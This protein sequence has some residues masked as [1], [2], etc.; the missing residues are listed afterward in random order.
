MQAKGAPAMLR[1][2]L[3]RSTRSAVFS[4]V[5]FA[6]IARADQQTVAWL[7]GVGSWNNAAMWSGGVVPNNS[8]TTTYNVLIDGGRAGASTVMATGAANNFAVD[9]LA[10]DA[11]DQFTAGTLSITHSLLL[12]G[13]LSLQS[14]S[15]LLGGS[16]E[17]AG[18]GTLE[19]MPGLA[20]VY[21]RFEAQ[22]G[23]L[24]IGEGITVRGGTGG[25][26]RWW[27]SISSLGSPTAALVN[28][29]R[30]V[31][32]GSAYR[33]ELRLRANAIENTGTIEAIN[34]S[35][36][37]IS[38]PFSM[39]SIGHLDY[40]GGSLAVYGALDNTG[41]ELLVDAVHGGL[42]INGTLRGGTLTTRDN[43]VV[44]VGEGYAANLDG[45]LLNA[46]TIKARGG[47]TVPAGQRFE[48]FADI[49]L[50]PP[51][52]LY[53]GAYL[54]AASGTTHITKGIRVHGGT[55]DMASYLGGGVGRDGQPLVNEGSIEADS[56][57]IMFVR[58]SGIDNLGTFGAMNGSHLS[59]RN[60]VTFGSGSHYV[61]E[62]TGSMSVAGDLDL[63]SIANFLD[64]KPRPDRKSYDGDV[65]LTY[66]GNRTGIFELT[67][68]EI[69]VGY[70]ADKTI[71]IW[72]RPPVP[73]SSLL[74]GIAGVALLRR[75]LRTGKRRH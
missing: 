56:G 26:E 28:H 65:I 50:Q 64:I 2:T 15:V 55:F 8:G 36:I 67:T 6:G 45:V 10:I 35:V 22:N 59:V 42:V 18:S 20:F 75:R 48:G 16:G 60:S 72:G 51:A 54:A 39:A 61:V 25:T 17:V 24:T 66:S 43:R 68:E 41:Q 29:G 9:S 58:G 46:V 49:E 52:D 53:F 21:Q 69:Y 71:R 34:G 5:L 14:G 37:G 27:P 62:G 44:S 23:T 1:K 38:A 4:A 12:N 31:A 19:F 13:T 32:G 3:R 33:Y 11:G 57:S 73:E 74:P 7:G 30:I 47:V 40:R 70:L 63:S